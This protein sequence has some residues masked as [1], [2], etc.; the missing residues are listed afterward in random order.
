MSETKQKFTKFIKCV[1][2]Q[3]EV[4][5]VIAKDEGELQEFQNILN[6]EA[7]K[8]INDI[9]ELTSKIKTSHKSYLIL[10]KN[11]DKN[12]YDFLVQYPTGQVEIFNSKKMKSETST[13]L[14]RDSAIIFLATSD[15]LNHIQKKGF[16]ILGN[17]GLTYQ[18]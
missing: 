16:D 3:K 1:S 4:S 13:P 7:F 17:S 5:L 15:N 18:D 9:Y 6:K 8:N 10:D 11:F 2:S 14:Y 12:I